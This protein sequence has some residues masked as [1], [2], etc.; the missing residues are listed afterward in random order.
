MALNDSALSLSVVEDIYRR[1]KESIKRNLE[2]VNNKLMKNVHN[3]NP[4]EV[5]LDKLCL[6]KHNQ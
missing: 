1:K 4:Y 5:S 3:L 2:F 6:F